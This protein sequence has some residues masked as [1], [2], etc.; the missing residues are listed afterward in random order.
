MVHSKFKYIA[1]VSLLFLLGFQV[2]GQSCYEGNNYCDN[3]VD[4]LLDCPNDPSWTQYFWYIAEKLPG[5]DAPGSPIPELVRED[6]GDYYFTPSNVPAAYLNQ[7]VMIVCRTGTPA[8]PGGSLSF[9]KVRIR[10]APEKFPLEAPDPAEACVGVQ[11]ELVLKGSQSSLTTYEL[12]VEGNA[13]SIGSYVG[14]NGND[15]V[16]PVTS[17]TANTYTYYVVADDGIC[18]SVMP[19]VRPS[20]TVYPNPTASAVND[21]PV[22]EGGDVSFANSTASGGTGTL[23]YAWTGP[24]SFGSSDLEPVINGI[25][26]AGAGTYRL[27]VADEKGCTNFDETN[28]TINTPPVGSISGTASVCQGANTDLTFTL[29]G[30]APW[31]LVY[32]DGSN[33]YVVNNINTSPHVETIVATSNASYTIKSLTDSNTPVCSAVTLSGQADITIIPRPASALSGDASI[34]DGSST[35]LSVNLAGSADWDITYT[36]GTN[37]YNVTA[38]ASP[39]TLPVSPVA[40]PVNAQTVY[41]YTITALNDA[42][43]V[44]QAVDMTGSATVTVNP[45]PA[46]ALVSDQT[47]NEFCPGTNV[48]FTASG[49]DEYVFYKGSIAPGNEV[50][51][52]SATATYSDNTLVNGDVIFVQGFDTDYLTDCSG[53]AN[54]SVT[55]FPEPQV[56]PSFDPVCDGGGLQLNANRTGGT[57]NYSFAWTHASNGFTSS[58]ENPLILAADKAT[59]DGVYTV[60]VT[61]GNSCVA[62]GDIDVTMTTL[63]T[64]TINGSP[65]VTTTEVCEGDAISLTAGGGISYSWALPGGGSTT[66]SIINIAAGVIGTHEGTYTVTVDDGTCTNTLDHEVVINSNPAVTLVSN[67]TNDEFCLGTN[68]TFTAG[69][70]NEY[71][72]Y[73]G[74]TFATATV[75]QARSATA[76]YSDNTLVDG[77][78]IWVEGFDT[79]HPTDCSAIASVQV[80]VN[81]VDASISISSP[82]AEICAGNPVTFNASTSGK[83]SGNYNYEFIRTRGGTPTTMQDGTSSIYTDNALQNGDEVHVVITDIDKGCVGTSAPVSIIVNPNPNVTIAVAPGTTICE[84]ENATFTANPGTFTNYAFFV[85]GVS[86]KSGTENFYES[87]TLANNSAVYVVAT[88]DKGCTASST[89]NIVM[90]VNTRPAPS[91]LTG[92][93]TPCANSTVTYTTESGSGESNW[94]WAV[95]GGTIDGAAD[96]ASVVVDWGIAGAGS[97]SVNY[98]NSNGCSAS[99]ATNVPVTIE[100]LPI[101]TLSGSTDVCVGGTYVYQTE[102]GQTNYDWTV[103]AGGAVNDLGDGRIEVT[104]NDAT[105]NPQ[106]VSVNYEN[107]AGCLAT[108]ATSTNVTVY[109]IPTVGL[110]GD[111]PVCNNSVGTYRTESGKSNYAWTVPAEGTVQSNDMDGTITVVWTT[112]GVYTI[113]VNYEESAAGCRA[114]NATEFDVTVNA[115]PTPSILTG[116]LTPCANSSVTYTTESGSGESNWSWVVTGGTISGPADQASV[117]VDWGV[118]GA[119]SISVNYDNSNGCSAS[120]ATNVP[121]TIEALPTVTLSG[122]TDVC[123]GGTYSYQTESGQTNYDWTVSAGGTINDLGDGRIEVTWNDA[124]SNPQTVS[125]NYENTAGCLATAATSTNVTVYPIPTVGLSGDTPVCNNSVGTYRTE[126]GKS[127]YAWT[128]PVEGTVQSN[129]MDGT[130]TVLWTTPGFHTISV[131]YQESAAG[132]SA[133]NATEFDVTVNAQ[134]TP[135]IL[136]GD[137]TP[138]ANSSVTYTTESGSGESNWS[139]VVTGGTI[140]G[141]AD[142]SS[143]IVD[144]GVAGAGSISVNYDNSDG[145]SA[146]T[147]TNVPVTIQALPTV[148]LS[149]ATDVCLGGNYIYQ[150]ESGQSNYDWT[151]SAGGTVNDLGD[152]RI[153]VTWNDATSNPQSVSVNYENTAGCLAAA[154]TSAN[155]NVNPIP[156]ATISSSDADNTICQDEEVTFTGTGGDIYEFFVNGTSVQGASATDKYV[157][158]ILADGDEVTVQVTNSATGCYT[159]SAGIIT[160]VNPNP[161]AG[162]SANPSGTIIAGTSV[163]LTGTGGAEYE[164]FV[165]GS[166]VQDRSA[167]DTYDSTSLAD[168]DAV[169]VNVYNGFGCISTATLNMS[170]LEGIL[171]LDVSSS[172]TE[173]CQG[174]VGVSIYLTA[175]QDG[176]TYDLIRT[177]D[178]NIIGTITHDGT[179]AVQWDNLP[180]TE[181]YR[182]EGYYLTVPADRFEMKNRITVTENP[183]PSVYQVNP[184]NGSETGCNAGVGWIIGVADSDN[185]INYNLLLNG[186]LVETVVGDGNAISFSAQSVIGVYTVQAVSS[187]GCSILMDG[188][189]T[190][191][192]DG[193][194]VPFNVYSIPTDGR[195][196]AGDV[197]IEIRLDG[198]LNSTVNYVVYKD[199]VDTGVSVPGNSGDIS[200]GL[201]TADGVYTVRV[202]SG[203]GCEFPMNGSVDVQTIALPVTHNLEATNGG[204]YCFGDGT[205]LQ[206]WLAGQELGVEYQL[207]L[208]GVA[209]GGPI[210]GTVTDNATPL[211]F[212]GTFLTTGTYSVTAAK[213][214][215][216]CQSPMNNTLDIVVD[217]LPF[218]FDVTSD[219]DYCTGS[220]TYLRLN[221]SEADVEYRW[222]REG[223]ATT[224]PWTDGTGGLLTFEIT[225]TDT[226]YI[227]GRKKDGVTSCTSEMNGRFAIAEKSY[228]DLSKL[229]SVKAGTGTDCSTG[230][231]VIVENSEAGVV[232]ELVKGGIRTGNIVIGN[233]ND[234]E[235]PNAI[236]DVAA[237]YNAYASLNGCE[238][239]LIDDVLINVPGAI[240]QYSV[241]GAG[242]IC[243]GD[244]GQQFGLSATESAVTYTLY[245]ADAPGSISGTAKGS[246]VGN[247]VAQLFPLVNE[248][249]EYFVIGDNGVDCAIEMLNRVTLT[250]NPLPVAFKMIGSGYFCDPSDGAEIGIDNSEASVTYTLQYDDGSGL[251]NIATA[252][253]VAGADTITFGKYVDLG[254]YKVVAITDKGCTSSMN[255]EV[256]VQQVAA[257]NNYL[258]VSDGTNYCNDQSGIELRMEHSEKAVVYEIFDA[259]N[260]LIA[261]VTGDGNDNL[262]LGIFNAG[263]YTVYGSYGGDACHTVMN[264]GASIEV[265][266]LVRPAKFNMSADAYDICGAAGTTLKLDGSELGY[267]YQLYVAGVH[268]TTSDIVGTA[269]PISWAITST[270]S[271]IVSYEIRAVSGGTC[272]LS[273]GSVEINYKDAPVVPSVLRPDGDSYCDFNSGVRVGVEATVAG[274]SY[275]LIETSG[276]S[277]VGFI[278]GDGTDKFFSGLIGGTTDYS[279]VATVN[280]SGCS[281]STT[282]FTITA[283]RSANIYS[284]SSDVE[285][286][287]T[288]T[289]IIITLSGSDT[290]VD[291]ELNTDGIPS[292]TLTSGTGNSLTWTVTEPVEGEVIYEVVANPGVACELSMGTVDVS[293]NLSPS[294]FELV[295][296]GG[297]S[298]YCADETG[299]RLGLDGSQNNIGYRLYNMDNE[300][301]D[302]KTGDGNPFYFI[303]VHVA[304]T[305]RVDAVDFGTGCVSD[306]TGAIILIENS[307]PLTDIAMEPENGPATVTEITLTTTEDGVSYQLIKDGVDYGASVDAPGGSAG[308]SLGTPS[309]MGVYTVRATNMTTGCTSILNDQTILDSQNIDEKDFMSAKAVVDDPF[310]PNE[311]RTIRLLNSQPEVVYTLIRDGFKLSGKTGVGNGNDI[312]II[313]DTPLDDD[314]SNGILNYGIFAEYPGTSIS[315]TF[316]KTIKIFAWPSKFDAVRDTLRINPGFTEGTIDLASNDL[317]S[318]SFYVDPVADAFDYSWA[319]VYDF[320]KKDPEA[321]DNIPYFGNVSLESDGTILKYSKRPNFTS[322]DSVSY[323]INLLGCGPTHNDTTTVLVIAG[324]E[325]IN[326]QAILIPNV[327]T[328]N[329]DG[330]N[331]YF[332]IVGIERLSSSKLEVFNRWG[333]LVY[334]SKGQAYENDWDGSGS[335]AAMV[336]LGDK[337]PSGTYFY[338]FSVTVIGSEGKEITQE[339]SGY[340]ELRR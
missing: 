150:T 227:V 171:L 316:A 223:D 126:S 265:T 134:P 168:G 70:A 105:S 219:G 277:S 232:Y 31:T 10:Q 338:V 215:V 121:V 283:N 139:W 336:S 166:K 58:D 286:T 172:A 152:G 269:N 266:E 101:V 155:V 183:L 249:G 131:N 125:V 293:Y 165:N 206:L 71:I 133:A 190:I 315:K 245:L 309:S 82:G 50:Q 328:P 216:G 96:Q 297:V 118:A 204:H 301:V 162:I 224:G 77:D 49:A 233:G 262:V 74:P 231:I 100:A 34:C 182:I 167:D 64:P 63:P 41:P 53:T 258:V 212:P 200:L 19:D 240:N 36:D 75:V 220:V 196:C 280:S 314:R 86:V 137:L 184:Y 176:V 279:V 243:N 290:G 122:S 32:T 11:F 169:S 9:A 65:I 306:M 222:E 246:F 117:V 142:Q 322:T 272:D 221:G 320:I 267:T 102:S 98:D 6:A 274:I 73:K 318:L 294:V 191:N 163:V 284:V 44:A 288:S 43:C 90:T 209:Q 13:S 47:N 8:A 229:L 15:V 340:I 129:D 259:T 104:W 325:S 113:S 37:T 230:A 83:G 195:Y 339:Y 296:E 141:P 285:K 54:V 30:V 143:V 188:A 179:N 110:S 55:V 23:S 299:I 292:G 140:N 181:E 170:V 106:T 321:S 132:C 275:Q 173:H 116:D 260:K 109:P 197:G 158:T 78:I 256:V 335:E 199:G 291:Y 207:Y 329:G 332:E 89:P 5:F 238:D 107:A 69:S 263:S 145:C 185:N 35:N 7:V 281:T 194:D 56:T 24:N 282:P 201:F 205:G 178:N 239:L 2:N 79:S 66:G 248:E 91:I 12:F 198:S 156:A 95:T 319:V 22:C 302:Y 250:V 210:T 92:D 270:T 111:T 29:T 72:F 242:D 211:F 236:V 28:V 144:W 84:G 253:G 257:P 330:M 149:G 87:S 123:V 62:N 225:G 130:I 120:T 154:A 192:G 307:L 1:L 252:V 18:S 244:P 298:E 235:F 146:S 112:P 103:S 180:G 124:T 331:E 327:I 304:G 161:V 157:T 254:A 21:S 303:N 60:T 289:N 85:N 42:N 119:G 186:A 241:T 159:L 226:Y 334:R 203:S 247:G 127:N 337:L 67:Q 295:S 45:I 273:M 208:G 175:P 261:S 61:D 228:A 324:N 278:Q 135:S 68:V 268:E 17:F 287:C 48:T 26:S 187:F 237:T 39:F 52:R 57:A 305:Y 138:C 193:S 4:V 300:V 33:D 97:I 255:G 3:G 94:S 147:A 114:A 160:T 27:T 40:N 308:I 93:L 46:V 313:D 136:T 326:D 202:L 333:T 213:P 20:V 217:P 264:S 14:D 251:G 317:P 276:G 151:V 164:F 108:A 38:S 81:N 323:Y 128:V 174:D 312:E 51:G 234:I 310:C 218:A 311:D 80:V 99:T 115:Q 153:E 25:G 214:G 16:M 148:T 88:S 177:S 189:F 76:D 59:Y 271:G